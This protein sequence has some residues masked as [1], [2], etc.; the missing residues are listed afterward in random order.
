MPY[1]K[2]TFDEPPRFLREWEH[3]YHPHGVFI[4]D[5]LAYKSSMKRRHGL[6]T[7]LIKVGTL[8]RIVRKL[9]R[10]KKIFMFD[11]KLLEVT[12]LPYI[13][14]FD[15]TRLIHATNEASWK[16]LTRLNEKSAGS[17]VGDLVWITQLQNKVFREVIPSYP[18]IVTNHNT[19][20]GL[21]KRK[22]DFKEFMNVL[23]GEF[24]FKGIKPPSF[25]EYERCSLQMSP[26]LNEA[27]RRF[28]E[29]KRK[30]G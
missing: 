28:K 10:D 25:N 20:Y 22:K 30:R 29:E 13:P 17:L 15:V 18:L 6:P 19:E 14:S 7:F 1:T 24:R 8:E 4:G 27:F 3:K 23:Y 12:E 9:I 16:S 26:V 21:L 2:L 5:L 11:Q